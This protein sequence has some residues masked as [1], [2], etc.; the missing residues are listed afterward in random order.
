MDVPPLHLEERA[1]RPQVL[2]GWWGDGGNGR[3]MGGVE[4]GRGG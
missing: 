1:K 3:R 2:D 4:G